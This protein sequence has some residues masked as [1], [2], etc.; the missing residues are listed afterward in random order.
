M[1]ARV[2]KR[3]NLAALPLVAPFEL[4]YALLF[5]LP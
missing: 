5:V 3:D 4:V 1:D 2:R